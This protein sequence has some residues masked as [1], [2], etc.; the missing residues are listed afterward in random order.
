MMENAAALNIGTGG[1]T[2]LSISSNGQVRIGNAFTTNGILD[3]QYDAAVFNAPRITDTR[4]FAVNQ[5][6]GID[7]MGQYSS[8]TNNTER[9]GSI[10]GK[11]ENS[12]D[13]NVNGYLQFRTNNVER[14]R[15]TSGGNVL[16]GTTSLL[17]GYNAHNIVRSSQSSYAC[18]ISQEDLNTTNSSTL[19]LNRLETG[20]TTQG[21][22]LVCRQGNAGSG[23]NRLTIFNNGNVENSNNSYGQISDIKLKENIA[24]ATPK[25]D[26]LLKVKVKNF[27]FIGDNTKQI[28][29]IA[30]EL[31]EIFPSMIDE[32]PDTEDREVT[33]E[34]GNV[35]TEIVDLG[36]T[37]KSVKYSVFTPMLIKAIQEQQT[38]IE[39]LKSRI[40]TLEG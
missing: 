14:M 24:D 18:I 20:S 19:Q 11:K 10:Y 3:V 8:T 25:L 5:G 23:T 27:N 22:F 35:T 30:Q 28:G 6:G 21:Y 38:I 34:E 1:A 2:K 17:G 32:S 16:I 36:T 33:D 29:V 15:I 7:F 37:T 13:G 9:F 4:S 40:E 31:E 39:D 26:D 12:T